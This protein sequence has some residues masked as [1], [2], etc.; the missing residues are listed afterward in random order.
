MKKNI[1][2]SIVIITFFT[3]CTKRLDD[4]LFNNDNTITAYE[5][6]NFQGPVSVDLEGKYVV[7]ENRITVF[8]FEI[9]HEGEKHTIAAIYTGDINRIAEDTVIMYC[10]GNRDHMDFYWP[11]QK[12]YSHLGKL[13]RFGVLM[14]DYP[15][16]GLSTGKPTE[17]NMY[18]AVDGAL[19]WL[20]SNGLT[21]DRLVM[22]GFS[23]GSAPTCKITAGNY[24][25]NPSKIIL[26]APFASAEVMIH[27][28]S[29]LSIPASFLVNVKIDNAEQIKQVN[30]PLLWIHGV[31]DDFLAIDSHGELVFKNHN[32]DYKIPVRVPGGGHESVPVFMGIDVYSNTILNFITGKLN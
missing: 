11:R 27:D 26:E 9:E 5:L 24:A 20:K 6:D 7:P 1:F 17:G 2:L 8:D 16:F 14:I 23:L 15:G 25:M 28:A 3:S 29:K 21:D 32:G 13:G 19:K 18:A 30:V 10:H 12:I 4:F 22:Y 31:K